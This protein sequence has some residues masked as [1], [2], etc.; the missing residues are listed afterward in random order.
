MQQDIDVGERQNYIKH[1]QDTGSEEKEDRSEH[2]PSR[3][4]TTAPPKAG[5]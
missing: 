2:R 1:R 4:K 5:L 3:T